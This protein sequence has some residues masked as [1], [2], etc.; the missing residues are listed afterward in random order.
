M[1]SNG[2]SQVEAVG[3]RSCSGCWV[4]ADEG[5]QVGK[6]RQQQGSSKVNEEATTDT[7]RA[8]A[9]RQYLQ[10]VIVFIFGLC[11]GLYAYALI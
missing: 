4:S 9:Q 8:F 3:G 7:K 2:E 6:R 1:A 10:V 5:C 11:R